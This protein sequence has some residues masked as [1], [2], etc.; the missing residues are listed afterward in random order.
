MEK[1]ENQFFLHKKI[2]ERA[3]TNEPI[4]SNPNS[5]LFSLVCVMSEC[6]YCTSVCVCGM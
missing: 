3:K 1:H 5:S 6:L 4:A 2:V